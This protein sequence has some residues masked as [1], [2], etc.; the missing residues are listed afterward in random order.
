MDKSSILLDIPELGSIH[1]Y[2]TRF[3]HPDHSYVDINLVPT[4]TTIYY[5]PNREFFMV[6]YG[7]NI[8]HLT[9]NSLIG[10]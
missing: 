5:S 3:G 7:N 2:S 6:S 10:D 9:I 4:Q 1:T 8:E